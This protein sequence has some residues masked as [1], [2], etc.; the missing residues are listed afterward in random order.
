LAKKSLI[1]STV[2]TLFSSVNYKLI[3]NDGVAFYPA[4][5]FI[6]LFVVMPRFRSTGTCNITGSF[7]FYCEVYQCG[8]KIR[9]NDVDTCTR[10]L[11]LYACDY[12]KLLISACNYLVA[13]HGMHIYIYSWRNTFYVVPGLSDVSWLQ[14]LTALNDGSTTAGGQCECPV[15]YVRSDFVL[16]MVIL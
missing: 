10:S 2:D 11:L 9:S 1:S 8:L 15:G 7:G 12:H 6:N 3:D 5:T 4:I 16:Q 13:L 14:F